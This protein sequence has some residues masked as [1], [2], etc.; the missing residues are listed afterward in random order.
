MVKSAA[1]VDWR[2]FIKN[3]HDFS[4]PDIELIYIVEN[5]NTL[6]QINCGTY[7]LFWDFAFKFCNTA[8]IMPCF[9]D[10][11]FTPFLSGLK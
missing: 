7:F 9:W 8:W 10:F 2:W 11:V 1:S 3:A 5:H 4:P 6:I